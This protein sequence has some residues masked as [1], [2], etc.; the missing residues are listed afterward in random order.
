MGTGFTP[1]ILTDG[2]FEYQGDTYAISITF[3]SDDS[4][5]KPF[6]MVSNCILDVEMSVK[7]NRLYSDGFIRYKDMD[8]DVPK[9]FQKFGQK[10]MIS[11]YMVKTDT[12]DPTQCMEVEDRD[13]FSHIFYVDNVRIDKREEDGITYTIE[14]VGIEYLGITNHVDYSN[15]DVGGESLVQFIK[16]M[17]VQYAGQQVDESFD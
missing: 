4:D 2:T 12:E 17:L 11:F 6:A 13:R 7:L 5:K 8:G 10:C 15:Y 9:I 14:L 1:N 3:P 16:K